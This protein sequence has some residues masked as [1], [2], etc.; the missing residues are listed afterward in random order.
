M[1]C[2]KTTLAKIPVLNLSICKDFI[3]QHTR[4]KIRIRDYE[5]ITASFGLSNWMAPGENRGSRPVLCEKM[6]LCCFF[7]YKQGE[8]AW[9]IPT[10][11]YWHAT[12]FLLPDNYAHRS[13]VRKALSEDEEWIKVQRELRKCHVK[14]V[15]WTTKQDGTYS[16]NQIIDNKFYSMQCKSW[17]VHIT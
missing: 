2:V 14:Q 13:A 5:S 15:T 11:A 1:G 17:S 16:I 3:S 12:L 6:F 10:S 7:P 4:H 8:K 9:H